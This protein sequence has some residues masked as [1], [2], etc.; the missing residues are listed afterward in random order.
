PSQGEGRMSLAATLEPSGPKPK[1]LTAG[2]VGLYVFLV[3]AALFFLL[4]LYVMLLT[5][6]KTMEEIRFGNIFDWP[7][8]FSFAAWVK[9]WTS[10]CTGLVCDGIRVGFWNSVRIL[11]PSVILSI[12]AGALTGY[13]LSFWRARGAE[14]VFAI[15]LLGAFIPYQVF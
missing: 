6:L 4:P 2:R 11:I 1:Q 12:L 15:L 7:R 5:S 9:A 13:A 14:L 8:A 3:I 10:A